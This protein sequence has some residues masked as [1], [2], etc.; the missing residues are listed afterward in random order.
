MCSARP[1]T[2]WSPFGATP[3]THHLIGE[4]RLR[5]IKPGVH[6]VNVARGTLVDS[7]ALL[8]ALDDGRVARASLHVADGE[9]LAGQID[10]AAGY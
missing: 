7:S 5:R 1:I 8:A 3:E 9:P 2:S 4:A 6:L 10:V